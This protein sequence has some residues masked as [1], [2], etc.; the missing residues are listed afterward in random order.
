MPEQSSRYQRISLALF[1]ALAVVSCIAAPYPR[2]LLLQ[3]APTVLFVSAMIATNGRFCFSNWAY[4]GIL[5]FMTLHLLGARY[6]YSNVPYDEWSRMLFGIGVSEQFGFQ[7]NHYDRLV[8]FAFGFCLSYPALEL[9]R[10]WKMAP[11]P[12]SYY[13][14]VE[15]I[16]AGSVLYELGEW[17]V[18]IIFAPEWADRYLGQQGDMWD[19]HKDMGLA[20]IGA[21][22]TMCATCACERRCRRSAAGS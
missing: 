6:V 12:W 15:A 21:T 4:S 19:A 16:V 22:L 11:D 2:D 14:A 3:H 9:I 5:A 18:A 1:C 10:R 20:L 17:L 7:R 13:F 8:H